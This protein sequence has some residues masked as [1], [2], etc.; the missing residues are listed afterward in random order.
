[1]PEQRVVADASRRTLAERQD[2]VFVK[3]LESDAEADEVAARVRQCFEDDFEVEGQR[4]RLSDSVGLAFAAHRN[5]TVDELIGEADAAMYRD[6]DRRSGP[7]R[8]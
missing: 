5:V 6:K 2:A 1:M 8:P 7:D 3:D 4:R